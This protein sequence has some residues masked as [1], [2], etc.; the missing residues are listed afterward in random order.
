MGNIT[1]KKNSEIDWNW[2][3]VVIDNMYHVT[4]VWQNYHEITNITS[5]THHKRSCRYTKQT[6]ATESTGFY[7]KKR[8]TVH[9]INGDIYKR[10]LQINCGH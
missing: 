5:S 10:Q 9:V 8:W 1:N 6:Y 2:N 3:C 7:Y 4:Q